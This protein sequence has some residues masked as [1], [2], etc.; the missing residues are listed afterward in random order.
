M[1]LFE[2]KFC[3]VCSEKIGLLGN[4]KLEDGNMCSTC[5]KK[6]SPFTTDRKK[7]SLADIKEH[8]AYREAN[9]PKVAAFKM[10]RQFGESTKVLVDDSNGTFIVTNSKRWQDENPD[11][12][13]ISQ[14]TG[15][16]PDMR[17]HSTEI[18]T[19]DAQGKTVS[20]SP[21]RYEYSYDFYITVE[22]NSP[23]F[24]EINFKLNGFSVDRGTREIG[25]AHV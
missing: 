9:K 6:L 23:Y 20:Y 2:K 13:N 5:A 25:R 19:T 3:D 1:G 12:I 7:T 21:P 16:Y 17:E 8:L 15:C 10:S 24:S 11:V 22:I 4:R 14:V 18:K